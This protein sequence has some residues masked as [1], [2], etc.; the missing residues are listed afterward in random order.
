ML[1]AQ[2][3]AGAII[4]IHFFGGLGMFLYGMHVMASGLQKSAGDKMKALLEA[5]TKTK[6]MGLLLGVGVTAIIQSSSAT[7]VMVVGFVNAG[8]MNLSQSIGIIMGANIGTTATS[9][10]VSS[11]EWA[12]VLEPANLA[13]VPIACGVTM[14][15]FVQRRGVK[16]AG[17]ILIGFG[18]LFAGMNM[19]TDAVNP[20]K[21]SPVFA[22]L[23]VLLGKNPLYGIL[24]GTII[25]GIIQSSSASVGI[26][27]S[28]AAVQLVPWSSAVYIILGQ[29]IG[30]CITAMLS[31]IG[32]NQNAKSAAYIHLF[33][34][35]VGAVVFGALAALYFGTVGAQWGGALITLT[36]ISVVHTTFNMANTVLLYPFSDQL[37]AV[38]QKIGARTSLKEPEAQAEAV[39]VHLDDRILTSPSFAIEN[40]MK[41]I[42]RMG[43]FSLENLKIAT[44]ALLE[45]NAG[46]ASKVYETETTIDILEKTITSYMVKICNAESITSAE[47]EVVTSLFH[48]VHDIERVGD[49]SENI[50]ELAEMSLTDDVSLSSQGLWELTQ[51]VN[52]TVTCFTNSLLALQNTDTASAQ[53]VVEQE[54][55]LDEMKDQFRAAHIERLSNHLC[56]V[57]NGVIFLDA[58]T[59]LE[60]V[61]DHAL[62]IAQVVLQLKGSRA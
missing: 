11:V 58:L 36:Q 31:S 44:Q 16:Q 17:E 5:L 19:M 8:I 38:A 42:V 46:K 54:Q 13:P 49:H 57:T 40:C 56:T 1:E 9:W 20:L 34:N 35:I 3:A 2:G 51:M 28:L 52:M 10:I 61:S 7:T 24:A 37:I 62:N 12:K 48:T 22:D 47:N 29:N 55:R 6:L 53:L 30:T 39:V 4:F 60:R 26:L 23:F 50:A 59:N 14:L 25:T 43:Y 15:L 45:K 18:V 21:N 32:A 33:F 41:E 27:Q